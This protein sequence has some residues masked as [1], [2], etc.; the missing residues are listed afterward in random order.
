MT[1]PRLSPLGHAHLNCL[2]R[3]ATASF[4]PTQGLRALGQIPDLPDPEGAEAG[5]EVPRLCSGSVQSHPGAR[6]SGQQGH[7]QYQ[8][9]SLARVLDRQGSLVGVGDLAAD[10]QTEAG[11]FR[12]A[13]A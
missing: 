12:I 7:A 10:G 9:R 6:R 3:Y 11:A 4:D 2:G 8:T 13:G 5:S 1:S